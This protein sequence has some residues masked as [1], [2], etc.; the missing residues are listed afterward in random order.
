LLHSPVAFASGQPFM[1][2]I[3]LRDLGMVAPRPLF[4]NITFNFGPGDRVGIV[5]VNGAGKS[6]LLRCVA[7]QIN[8]DEGTVV[9]QRLLS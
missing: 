5:A 9:L 4:Q 2:L 7:S 8:P 3:S 1:A 6:T